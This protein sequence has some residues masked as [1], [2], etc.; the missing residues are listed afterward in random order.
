MSIGGRLK[1]IG[2][3]V[4]PSGKAQVNVVGDR[5]SKGDVSAAGA[6][7]G[8]WQDRLSG[9][10]DAD[11]AFRDKTI[12]DVGCSLGVIDYE[13]SKYAPKLVHG[14]DIHEASVEVA[15]S[16]FL[17]VDVESNFWTL[18][19]RDGDALR[20][21][22]NRDYDIILCLAVDQH[23]RKQIGDRA[24]D[25]MQY[26]LSRCTSTLLFRGTPNSESAVLDLARNNGFE[27][28]YR[29]HASGSIAPLIRFDRTK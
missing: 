29:G 8:T 28:T 16:I 23:V 14:C 9:I 11:C 15:R 27:E 17:A 6:F 5:L 10:A 2:R 18:D 4:F 1:I 3:Q 12:L 7:S 20:Q 19:L 13:I 22:V 21:T 24:D 26:L 25:V